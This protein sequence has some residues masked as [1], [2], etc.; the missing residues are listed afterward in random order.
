[1]VKEFYC[2]SNL[3]F[4]KKVVIVH[5]REYKSNFISIYSRNKVHISIV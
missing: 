3:Y 1:M 2:P 4:V 5:R